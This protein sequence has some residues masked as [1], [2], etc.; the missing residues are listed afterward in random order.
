MLE[1][2]LKLNAMAAPTQIAIAGGPGNDEIA[3]IP[4]RAEI[5]SSKNN[6]MLSAPIGL[7]E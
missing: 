3:T 7:C 6:N 4:A 5:N 1:L 2:G